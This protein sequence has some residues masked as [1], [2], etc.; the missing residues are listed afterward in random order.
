MET[1]SVPV[2]KVGEE[3]GAFTQT[4]TLKQA[5]LNQ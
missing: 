4:V 5:F 2:H 3:V 1:G